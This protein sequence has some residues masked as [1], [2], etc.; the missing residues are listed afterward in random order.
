MKGYPAERVKS[1]DPTDWKGEI[2]T[3]LERL[4]D[5]LN[6][7]EGFYGTITA[8]DNFQT[9]Y[10]I[11]VNDSSRGLILLDNGNPARYWR[12]T[13]DAAMETVIMTNLGNSL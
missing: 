13:I 1:D 10:D 8:K 11:I 3:I 9:N 2:N 5:R 4:N 6:A 12:L 7:L